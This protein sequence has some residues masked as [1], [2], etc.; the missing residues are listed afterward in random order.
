MPT[1]GSP[2]ASSLASGCWASQSI[3]AD[4]SRPSASGE[5]TVT[6]PPL[7][8][9]PRESQ[10]RTLKPALRRAP[11]PT[12]PVVS[13]LLASGSVSREPPQPWPSRIVGAFPPP[14][15]GWNESTIWVPS[16]ELMVASRACAAA[17]AA[18]KAARTS[19]WTRERMTPRWYPIR[20]VLVRQ[21]AS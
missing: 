14:G 11:T 3:S 8:P 16:K 15:A 4:T 12:L 6:V 13:S 17:G 7:L 21:G 10:V 5:S 9:K 1:R 18:R 2:A 19:V 20:R